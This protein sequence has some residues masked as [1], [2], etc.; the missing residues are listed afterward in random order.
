M[1]SD[2][3]HGDVRRL[4]PEIPAETW[5]GEMLELEPVDEAAPPAGPRRAVEDG[6]HRH[7]RARPGR[8]RPHLDL[9][10]GGR[11]TAGRGHRGVGVAGVGI[12]AAMDIDLTKVRGWLN[13]RDDPTFW[14]R[15]RDICGLYLSPPE[16]ALVLSV[17]EK[18]SIQAKQRRHPDQPARRARRRRREFE[19]VRHGTASLFAALDVHSGQVRAVPVPGKNDSVNFCEFLDGSTRA[20]TRRWRYTSSS[21]TAPATSPRRRR[22]GSPPTPDARA[23]PASSRCRSASSTSR[24]RLPRGEPGGPEGVREKVAPVEPGRADRRRICDA[25]PRTGCSHDPGRSSPQGRP[26][27]REAPADAGRSQVGERST[28]EAPSAK[29]RADCSSASIPTASIPTRPATLT[30]TTTS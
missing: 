11:G 29:G 30:R 12:L 16:R 9:R 25:S 10:R 2:H 21:T 18:T 7:L 26:A 23:G 5:R 27:R 15:V 22:R 14:E 1:C 3:D 20:S 4:E 17:D 6:G 8:P 28:G 19:Y 24:R 13:R